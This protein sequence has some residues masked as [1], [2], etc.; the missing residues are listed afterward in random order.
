MRNLPHSFLCLCFIVVGALAQGDLITGTVQSG[1]DTPTPIPN[2]QVI[3]Y[4]ATNGAPVVRGSAISDASGIFAIDS[5]VRKTSGTFYIRAKLTERNEFIALLGTELPANVIVNEL[6]TVAG[7]YA[8]AQLS[9]GSQIY[10]SPLAL[11]IA[12]GMSENLVNH[13]TGDSA[14][15]MLDGPN[16]DQTNSLRT[17]RSLG[18]VLH[19]CLDS[20]AVTTEFLN[21]STPSGYPAPATTAIALSQLAQRPAT[22][23]SDI[24]T[25]SLL[26][27]IYD[28]HLTSAVESWVIAVKV[29]VSN[30]IDPAVD[31]FGGPANVGFDSKG[32]AWI[33]NNVVQ[34]TGNSTDICMVLKPNGKPSDGT[35]DRPVSPIRGHGL[36]GVGWGVSVDSKDQVWFGNFGWGPTSDA[37]NY[38]TQAREGNGSVVTLTAEGDFLSPEDGIYQGPLRVQAIEP[39]ADDNIWI[40][41]LG[42]DSLFFFPEGDSSRSVGIYQYT[43]AGPF[44]IGITPDGDAWMSNSGGIA[45]KYQSSI[46]R[47]ELNAQG[48]PEQVFLKEIGN[49]LKVVASDSYGNAWLA[50]Q[51]DS[52]VY[53]FAADATG[54]DDP[55][56]AYTDI[57]G[58]DGPWGLCVD[59]DDNIWIGNFGALE[60]GQFSHGRVTQLAGANPATRP[61]GLSMGDPMSPDV[62]FRV[63]SAG[64]PVKLANGENLYGQ[65][66]NGDVL[67]YAPQMRSTSVQIDRAGNLWTFNNWKPPF[68]NDVEVNPGGDG[69]LI[70][71]GLAPPPAKYAGEADADT[72]GDGLT[73]SFE[74]QI[75]NFDPNDDITTYSDVNPNGDF[76]GDGLI[77]T[78][79]QAYGSSPTSTDSDGDYYLDKDEVDMGTDPT[80][81]MS[82]PINTQMVGTTEFQFDTILGYLYQVQFTEDL[83]VWF[84]YGEPIVGDGNTTTVEVPFVGGGNNSEFYR[85]VVRPPVE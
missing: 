84:N 51:G 71:V 82:L 27:P 1:V 14:V 64:E 38:P 11:S 69:I 39:D 20:A 21:K 83:R 43:N 52:K 72:D 12:A 37:D 54:D 17:K 5:A 34:G 18:N 41:S 58:L 33:A 9:D 79:E 29:N 55:I 35:N 44:G 76:D 16:S 46:A 40:A 45:G 78:T 77:E 67:S 56:G 4:E 3:L 49:T 75:I 73:D 26:D 7:A 32:Y 24:F 47:F 65:E 6:T 70:F 60:P 36:R 23:A 50:S 8:S 42:N 22:N 62:G 10:G 68:L 28:R 30:P 63:E 19:A 80:N 2:A 48:K 13:Q 66:G 85:V 81:S 61:P 15:V 74:D 57:G 25:L 59:G 53:V 31:L